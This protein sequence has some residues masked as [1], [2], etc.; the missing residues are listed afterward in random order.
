MTGRQSARQTSL[1]VGRHD[2]LFAVYRLVLT[3]H[4]SAG[5]T[6]YVHPLVKHTDT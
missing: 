3:S 6:T 1:G 2:A 5:P 4:T